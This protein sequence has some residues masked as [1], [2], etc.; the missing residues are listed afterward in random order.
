M[1]LAEIKARR[2]NG[3][4][5]IHGVASEGRREEKKERKTLVPKKMAEHGGMPRRA[6]SSASVLVTW[7]PSP[8]GR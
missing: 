3:N 5:I 7:D 4:G 2:L 1:R 6:G 8:E